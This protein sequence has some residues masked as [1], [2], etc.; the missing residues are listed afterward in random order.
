MEASWVTSAAMC[1]RISRGRVEREGIA[2]WG[3]RRKGRPGESY[4]EWVVS[5]SK[6]MIE[7]TPSVT[8]FLRKPIFPFGD[9]RFRAANGKSDPHSLIAALD[10]PCLASLRN[11][12]RNSTLLA[13]FLRGCPT[14]NPHRLLSL[15]L[16]WGGLTPSSCLTASCLL[17][18]SRR[19]RLIPRCSVL[20]PR[21]FNS[22]WMDATSPVAADAVPALGRM[23]LNG[24]N[25]VRSV[26]TRRA[27]VDLHSRRFVAWR[28]SVVTRQVCKPLVSSVRVFL[29]ALSSFRSSMGMIACRSHLYPRSQG[30]I[31]SRSSLC[32]RLPLRAVRPPS[33]YLSKVPSPFS[34]S[35]P[36]AR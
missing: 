8:H 33:S 25:S 12:N 6:E 14:G 21:C 31:R 27:T 2:G 16:F 9:D 15:G 30:V 34:L 13:H 36:L 28:V 7:Y 4:K 10:S 1:S 32:T 19:S 29:P 5:P 35:D 22:L 17:C 26:C 11:R 18:S 24:R 23:L 3:I 20:H